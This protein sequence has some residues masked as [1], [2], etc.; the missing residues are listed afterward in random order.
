[1]RNGHIVP[2]LGRVELFKVRFMQQFMG[3]Q[4]TAKREPFLGGDSFFTK[5]TI[6][7]TA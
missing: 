1:M 7:Q 5:K 4:C 3:E 2:V 6:T